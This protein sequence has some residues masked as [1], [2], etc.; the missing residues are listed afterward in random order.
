MSIIEKALDKA[1]ELEQSSTH[2]KP[3][4][5]DPMEREAKTEAAVSSPEP[6]IDRAEPKIYAIDW[7]RLREKGMLGPEMAYSQLAEEYRLIKRP[8]LMNAFPDGD[9]G[10]E[11]ANLILVTSSVPG[12]GKTFSAV[13]LALSIAMERDKTVLLVDAD[14]AK[15]S[16]A[17]LLGIP[18]KA[19]L[20]D[21]LQDKTICFSDVLVKTD[22]PNLSLLPAGKLDSY[23]TELLASDAMKRLVKELSARYPDRVV[24][25]D[26]P[27]LLAASQG[28]VLATLVGQVVLVIEAES[29]PQYLVKESI[30]KLESCEIIGCVLN[31]T[32]KGFGFRYYGYGYGYGYGAYGQ[33]KPET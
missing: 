1:L 16:I 2:E 14:V 31:K 7:Q 12:E 20:I 26:S 29:T 28:P 8:L 11:R 10:I 3:G 22:I 30:A 13:N 21:L 19:G 18:A 25:F 5:Q 32:K 17:G 9:N 33:Q 4:R 23:S 6:T 24:I 27:P 15:P